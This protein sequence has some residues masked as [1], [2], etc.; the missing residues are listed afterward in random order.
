MDFISFSRDRRRTRGGI[1]YFVSGG[2]GDDGDTL[3]KKYISVT[4][5]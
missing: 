2:G 4:K 3:V 1:C 5:K